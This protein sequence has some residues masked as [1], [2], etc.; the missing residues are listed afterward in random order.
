M[1]SL[2]LMRHAQAL[3]QAVDGNDHD[4]P[5][6]ETGRLE[7]QRSAQRMLQA[8]LIPDLVLAS[9]ARRTAETAT[10]LL[11]AMALPSEVLR[12]DSKLYLASAAMLQQIIKRS[13]GTRRLLLVGHN[14]GLSALA[15]ELLRQRG[16]NLATAEFREVLQP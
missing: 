13:G 14:P 12:Y 9:P 15:A 4:R 1:E 7:A 10:L 2:I 16:L 11:Q 5:L 6:S 8:A 3:P